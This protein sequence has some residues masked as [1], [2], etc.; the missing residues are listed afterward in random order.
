MPKCFNYRCEKM[1][2]TVGWA[3]LFYGPDKMLR[4]GR[5]MP[6][7]FKDLK[8]SPDLQITCSYPMF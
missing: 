7:Y 4:G 5:V 2:W 8:I 1:L 6:K 3:K